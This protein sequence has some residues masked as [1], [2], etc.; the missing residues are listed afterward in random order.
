MTRAPTMYYQTIFGELIPVKFLGWSKTL[1]HADTRLYNAVIQFK[2]DG[3][4]Y[5]KG[6][7]I[8]TPSWS[9]LNKTRRIRGRQL[10]CNAKLPPVDPD[11]LI[12]TRS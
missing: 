10:V 9:V 5:E 1:T 11:N 3:G 6:E 7:V 8:H 2:R 12:A 4:C